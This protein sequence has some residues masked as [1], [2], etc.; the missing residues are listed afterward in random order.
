M[1]KSRGF[2]L[3]ELMVVITIIA[4]LA[5]IGLIAYSAFLKTSRDNK[6]QS[7]LKFIQSALEDYHG[8]TIF[9]P[10]AGTVNSKQGLNDFL[11]SLVSGGQFTSSIGTGLGTIPSSSKTYLGSVP[12]D[13][14]TATT[15]PYKYISS[16]TNIVTA[17]STCDNSTS[18]PCIS[19]CLYANLE[20]PA[21]ALNNAYTSCGSIANYNYAVT[22]P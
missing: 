5:I 1:S 9:Y 11:L 20:N 3:I 2:T 13:P 21:N 14:T 7:D 12:Q 18:I 19:Y 22:R 4:I 10:T 16:S 17:A 8:D 15:F 6:R